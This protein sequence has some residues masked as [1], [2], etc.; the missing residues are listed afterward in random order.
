MTNWNHSKIL[1]ET[2]WQATTFF[3]SEMMWTK[4]RPEII[5]ASHDSNIESQVYISCDFSINM[6][7]LVGCILLICTS[8][9]WVWVEMGLDCACFK[10]TK[11]ITSKWLQEEEWK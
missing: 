10:T 8:G 7:T 1:S 3:S 11:K 2:T 4:N 9:I 5:W 6:G